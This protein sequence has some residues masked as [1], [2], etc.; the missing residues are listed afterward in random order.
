MLSAISV[1]AAIV[2]TLA[3][4][5]SGPNRRAIGRRHYNNRHGDACGAREDRLG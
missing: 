1:T 5:R 4:A 2:A 3:Y